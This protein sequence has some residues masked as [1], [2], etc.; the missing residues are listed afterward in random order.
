MMVE[1]PI[2]IIGS[3]TMGLLHCEDIHGFVLGLEKANNLV[4]DLNARG[5]RFGQVFFTQPVNQITGINDVVFDP[6]LLPE[7]VT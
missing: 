4:E 5:H 2:Y 3:S 7:N 1:E 6:H